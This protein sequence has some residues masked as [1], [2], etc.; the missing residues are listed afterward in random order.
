MAGIARVDARMESTFFAEMKVVARADN[1]PL[2]AT[3]KRA[4][5]KEHIIVLAGICV[6]LDFGD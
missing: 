2:A 3:V 4:V 1:R 6:G 5:N